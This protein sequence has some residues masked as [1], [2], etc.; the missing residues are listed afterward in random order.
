MGT[1]V[2]RSLKQPKITPLPHE[3]G[4]QPK[5]QAGALIARDR[6]RPRYEH[7]YRTHERLS[8]HGVMA[9]KFPRVLVKHSS[10][11]VADLN[12]G[13]LE[14]GAYRIRYRSTDAFDKPY[15]TFKDFVVAG[16]DTS[17]AVPVAL[18]VDRG[19]RRVGERAKIF[20]HSGFKQQPILVTR[21]K[22]DR[23]V[24]QRIINES[25]VLD[26]PAEEI[27]SR[28]HWV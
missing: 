8:T 4:I 10:S 3:V 24:W 21:W 14:P 22:R 19:T 23:I 7:G 13:K 16:T 27:R 18:M 20:V 11:G 2:L 25:A 6:L 1:W 9:P 15:T 28:G 17:L 12:L 5:P 26:V